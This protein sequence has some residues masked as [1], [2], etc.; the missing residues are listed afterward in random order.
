MKTYWIGRH[1]EGMDLKLSEE[2]VSGLHAELVVTDAGQHYLTDCGSTNGTWHL[3]TGEWRKIRQTFVEREEPIR[4]G[5]YRTTVGQLLTRA[6][7]ALAGKTPSSR[8]VRHPETGE[9]V[10]EDDP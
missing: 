3:V 7:D 5:N 9:I 6:A 1:R 2:T 10:R 8:Y 4:L